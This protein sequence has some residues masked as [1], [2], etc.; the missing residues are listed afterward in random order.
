MPL[1]LVDNPVSR[2]IALMASGYKK[3]FGVK[4]LYVSVMAAALFPAMAGAAGPV[5]PSGADIDRAKPLERELIAPKRDTGITKVPEVGPQSQPPEQA[6]SIKF[7]LKNVKVEGVTVY[8]GDELASIYNDDLGKTITLDKVWAIAYAITQRYRTDGYFLTRAYVPAQ[9]VGDGRVVIRVVEG[10]I[11]DV[12]FANPEIAKSSI[13]Q[14]IIGNITSERPTRIETLE[15]Q[16]LLLTDVP[17]LAN[18]QG[19][20]VP[21]KG[22]KEGAVKLVFSERKEAKR[23]AFINFD[24]YG[25]QYLGPQELSAGWKGELIPMQATSV[26]GA[27]SVPTKELGAINATHTIP[28]TPELSLEMSAG[29]TRSE[30]GF[31][32]EPQDIKSK[33]VNAGIGVNYQAIRQRR[34]NLKLSAMLDARNSHSTILGTELSKD[35]IRAVRLKA[36][37]DKTDNWQGYNIAN[38]TLSHGIGGLGASDANDLNL[39]RAGAKPDFTKLEIDLKRLQ[40]IDADWGALLSLSGQKASGSLYSSEEFGYGGQTFGRAY[41]QSEVSGDDGVAAG[42]ELRYQTLPSWQG[43]GFTPYGFYDI[44]RAWNDN[45]GQK[46]VIDASSAGAGVRMNHEN[47]LS[48]TLQLA[49]PLTKNV[50]APLYGQ[51]G[52]NPRLGVQFG[53]AF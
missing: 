16:H 46:S 8:K 20:L 3:A 1:W 13:V 10:Y 40:Y 36:A 49:F 47:G 48:G 4:Y 6:K 28:L 2:Y 45:L 19:T 12:E 51:N 11:S 52:A 9:E 44:G 39:S 7:V 37:Y 32:L 53:Y 29:Y 23:N 5:L 21:I 30:P 14:D 18:Y 17:G 41:D 27:V 24:N 22:G 31:R 43:I 35:K 25:S 38:V 33:A 42:I 34:E 15:R 26:T 50:D